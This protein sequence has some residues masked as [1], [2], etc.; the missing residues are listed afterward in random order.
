MYCN[1]G[2]YV[3][4]RLR[5]VRKEVFPYAR[6]AVRKHLLTHVDNLFFHLKLV[7]IFVDTIVANVGYHLIEWGII[8]SFWFN[9]V[10]LCNSTAHFKNLIL[11]A[12]IAQAIFAKKQCCMTEISCS[13]FSHAPPPFVVLSDVEYLDTNLYQKIAFSF[14]LIP[15]SGASS[16]IPHQHLFLIGSGCSI[17][18]C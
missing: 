11:F 12:N 6:S 14:L 1:F 13:L 15:G 3:L 7:F 16:E 8:L 4:G 17:L 10:L 5:Y 9:F 18:D 2:W